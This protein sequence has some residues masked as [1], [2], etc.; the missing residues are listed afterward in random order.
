MGEESSVGGP[1]IHP[2]SARTLGRLRGSRAQGGAARSL[3]DCTGCG[4][5]RHFPVRAAGAVTSSPGWGA[6]LL[7]PADPPRA[8]PARSSTHSASSPVCLLLGGAAPALSGRARRLSPPRSYSGSSGF[9]S[10]ELS[11]RSGPHRG[12]I[13]SSLE[14]RVPGAAP[15]GAGTRAHTTRES[16]QW[17]WCWSP[18]RPR[19]ARS[20]P[21]LRLARPVS[22]RFPASPPR[23][24]PRIPV[25][26]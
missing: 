12:G 25:V 21:G 4:F 14:S 23:V 19:P 3:S 10:P 16:G 26:P 11:A 8:V 20:G 18:H 24:L 5:I 15:H 22:P 17:D 1:G 13:D 6:S 9:S 7:P 2:S